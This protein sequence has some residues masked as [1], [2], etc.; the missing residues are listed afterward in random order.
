[1]VW[2]HKRA[3]EGAASGTAGVE[4]GRP[5]EV[6]MAEHS[7]VLGVVAPHRDAALGGCTT[8]LPVYVRYFSTSHSI[9]QA[10]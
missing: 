7:V 5:A 4:S 1:M 6:D 10:Y 9:H 8:L 2:P 3:D